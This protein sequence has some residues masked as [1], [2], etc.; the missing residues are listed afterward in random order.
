M[1]LQATIFVSST[2]GIYNDVTTLDNELLMLLSMPSYDCVSLAKIQTS[3]QVYLDINLRTVSCEEQEIFQKHLHKEY[4]ILL[5]S[6][7]N[8]CSLL[9]KP[10]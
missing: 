8:V 9:H 1:W 10:L 3:I 4:Q 2:Q 6:I 7:E 5:Q